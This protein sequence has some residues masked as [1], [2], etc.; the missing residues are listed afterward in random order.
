MA[1]KRKAARLATEPE[2]CYLI[3]ATGCTGFVVSNVGESGL[4]ETAAHSLVGRVSVAVS[5]LSVDDHPNQHLTDPRRRS[6][7]SPISSLVVSRSETQRAE[8]GG[9]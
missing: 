8:R 3:A 4:R 5:E 7:G 2:P 1:R 6:A 9:R